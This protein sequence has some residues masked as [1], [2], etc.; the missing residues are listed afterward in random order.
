MEFLFHCT[1]NLVVP[2][3]SD[4]VSQPHKIMGKANV[5]IALLTFKRPMFTYAK[6]IGGGGKRH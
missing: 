2:V 6:R 5:Q 1:S 3:G 4:I